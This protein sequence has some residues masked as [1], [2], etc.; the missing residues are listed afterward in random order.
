MHSSMLDSNINCQ[1]FFT[2]HE[3]TVG[4]YD[5]DDKMI[6]LRVCTRLIP[7]YCVQSMMKVSRREFR[8]QPNSMTMKLQLFQFAR[9]YNPAMVRPN[10]TCVPSFSQFPVGSTHRQPIMHNIQCHTEM[11]IKRSSYNNMKRAIHSRNQL[12]RAVFFGAA[13]PSLFY[14]WV[15][16]KYRKAYPERD[17]VCA[18]VLRGFLYAGGLIEV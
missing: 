8:C 1:L 10:S 18:N 4:I 13:F 3:P 9:L 12:V 6:F 5:P 17:K 11:S 7:G 2:V 16:T 15:G 14:C